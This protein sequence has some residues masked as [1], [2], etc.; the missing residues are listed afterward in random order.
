MR[1]A[2]PLSSAHLVKIYQRGCPPAWP[3]QP[4]ARS[5]AGNASQP[6]T[7]RTACRCQPSWQHLRGRQPRRQ[8]PRQPRWLHL[9]WHQPGW[10]QPRWLHL[11]WHQPGW[12]QPRW[13]QPRW[14]QPRWYQP[15]RQQPDWQRHRWQQLAW[16]ARWQQPAWLAR[17]C[18]QWQR[19]RRPWYG[20]PWSRGRARWGHRCVVWRR[21]WY[22]R[23]I[24][25]G[26]AA[27][28]DGAAAAEDGAATAESIPAD[29]A[30]QA[31]PAIAE[32][33]QRRP[34]YRPRAASGHGGRR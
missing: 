11:R 4:Q 32:E 13:Y 26:A 7:D 25:A 30:N 29:A 16:L 33:S 5:S 20:G 10:Y 19:R 34:R 15:R 27:P 24:P 21:R 8:Q 3:G 2:V 17:W 14:Y 18:E 28:N 1:W 6:P 31:A 12:Y 9:R 23:R 22:G